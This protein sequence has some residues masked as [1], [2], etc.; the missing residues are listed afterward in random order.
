MAVEEQLTTMRRILEKHGPEV[1]LNISPQE[2]ELLLEYARRVLSVNQTMNLTRIRSAEEFA[3]KHIL[4]SLVCLRVGIPAGPGMDVGT[5]AG[6][7]GIPLRIANIKP[8]VLL[9]SLAKR[10]GFLK[11]TIAALNLTDIDAVHGRAEDMG[12][13]PQYREK[14]R[15]AVARAVAPLP[16][17]LEYTSPFV[18]RGGIVICMKGQDPSEEISEAATA[19]KKLGLEEQNRIYVRLPLDMGSRCLIVYQKTKAT[20][21]EYP[22]RAGT[23]AKKPL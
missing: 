6:F 7:P 4:D 17:L 13:D 8:I 16:V 18:A 5:G 23:P 2:L 10:V 14:F 20:P 9:D 12:S 1:D 22:R 15:W 11:D 3:V 19:A 21:R